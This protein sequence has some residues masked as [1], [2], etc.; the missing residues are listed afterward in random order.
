MEKAYNVSGHI[1]NELTRQTEPAN[2]C[3]PDEQHF[4]SCEN[5]QPRHGCGIV[6]Y[7][8]F[9]CEYVRKMP[10]H[11]QHHHEPTMMKVCSRMQTYWYR[12]KS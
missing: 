4:Y 2:T 5:P 8:N 3:R 9:N 10:S 6:G 1:Q 7:S 12:S 11:I